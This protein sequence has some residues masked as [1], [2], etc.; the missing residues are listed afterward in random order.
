MPPGAVV[1]NELP[2]QPGEAT[3][4]GTTMKKIERQPNRSIRTPPILGPMAGASTT[5]IPKMPLARPLL[6]R[7]ERAEDDDGRN[8]LHYAGGQTLGDAGGEHQRKLF[9]SPPAMPP[10]SSSSMVPA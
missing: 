7:L 4:S 3:Q 10:A 6:V 8:R 5:P 1:G 9:E 2:G